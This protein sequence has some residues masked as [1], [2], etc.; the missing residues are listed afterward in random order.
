VKKAHHKNLHS[1]YDFDA[2]RFH[3]FF[4]GF[5]CGFG[6]FQAKILKVLVGVVSC[7]R[8]VCIN[9]KTAKGREKFLIF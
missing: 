2:E 6:E 8:S 3:G 9:H 1:V 7:L 5:D 4:D